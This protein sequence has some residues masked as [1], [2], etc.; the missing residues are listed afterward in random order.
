[1]T[2][3]TYDST[4]RRLVVSAAAYCGPT[5]QGFCLSYLVIY[6]SN[7]LVFTYIETPSGDYCPRN[8]IKYDSTKRRLYIAS[9]STTCTDIVYA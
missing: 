3:V 8:P 6:S 1:M 4:Y 9:E 5:F 2:Y 7:R